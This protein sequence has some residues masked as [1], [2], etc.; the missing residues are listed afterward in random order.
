[1][2]YRV[3]RAFEH[4]N[5]LLNHLIKKGNIGKCVRQRTVR[6]DNTVNRVGTL[7]LNLYETVCLTIIFWRLNKARK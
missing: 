3:Y 2:P 1:M 7:P 6:Q 5:L 4:L